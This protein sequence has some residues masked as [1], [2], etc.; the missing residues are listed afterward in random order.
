MGTATDVVK[1]A[2]EAFG[3]G[4]VPAV[5]NLIA[6][7]VDWEFVG[8]PG[9]GYAGNRKNK[10]G[11]ADF[12]AEEARANEIHAF[13]PREFIEAGEHVTVLG[14]ES[15]TARDTKKKFESP[16]IHLFTVKNGKIVRWRGFF[17][18]A[19]RYGV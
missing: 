19:A 4:D 17:N 14:W 15:A 10:K 18:T 5:L 2:Y 7:E 16:W 9:L 13:E 11:V 1:K 12:F 3:K 6:D 8:S